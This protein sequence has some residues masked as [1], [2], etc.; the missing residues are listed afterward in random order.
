[1]ELIVAK[2][3]VEPSPTAADVSE[4]EESSST[5]C[6]HKSKKSL[7]KLTDI[8]KKIKANVKKGYLS[9][10]CDECLHNDPNSQ[11]IA[12]WLCVTCGFIGCE[13]E[14]HTQKHFQAARS[15]TDH[16]LYFS[17]NTRKFKC[18][19]CN[20]IMDGGEEANGPM[21][22]FV[23]DY[24]AFKK[25]AAPRSSLSEQN[26][27]SK[28]LLS[29]KSDVSS[30]S[31]T[32]SKK[33][34]YAE[35]T[36]RLKTVMQGKGKKVVDCFDESDR[37]DEQRQ[38][39]GLAVKVT[40][41]IISL[42]LIN[43][44]NTCFFNSTMQ[45]LMHT[46]TLRCYVKNVGI[47][48]EVE[49]GGCKVNVGEKQIEVS[50]TKLHLEGFSG[51]LNECLAYFLGEFY[52]GRNL[53]PSPLFSE[54]AIKAPRFRGW[55]QQDAHELLRCLMDGLRSEELQ[56][57]KNAIALNLK[58]PKS[59]VTKSINSEV[60]YMAKAMLQ[61]CGRPLLD[62]IFGGTLLQAIKCSKCGHLSCIYEEFLDLSIPIPSATSSKFLNETLK[63]HKPPSVI[64]KYQKKKE[65]VAARK[66]LSQPSCSLNE[67]LF[68]LPFSSDLFFYYLKRLRRK[69]RH[70]S[71]SSNR[72]DASDGEFA[73]AAQNE[74]DLEEDDD[75]AD[76]DLEFEK[77]CLDDVEDC[78]QTLGEEKDLQDNRSLDACLSAFT[79][80]EILSF[81]NAYECEKCC[82]SQNKNLRNGM[83][84]KTVDAEKRYFIYEPPTVLTLHLKR[85]EQHHSSS[86]RVS[87]SKVRGHVAFPLVLD[88]ASFC[89]KIVK[90][91]EKGR[92]KVLYALYGIVSHSGDLSGGHYVAY[93]RSRPAS[94]TANKFFCEAAKNLLPQN[95]NIDIFSEDTKESDKESLNG[96]WFYVSDSRVSAVDE[97][98][99]LDA[100]AYILFYERIA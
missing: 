28:N 17:L 55:A 62:A 65:K 37:K 19:C 73:S 35:S 5:M 13:K 87:T 6:K 16:P 89:T 83:K 50:R 22:T 63:I 95:P 74:S 23:N 57:Y 51:P 46:Y 18:F 92:R 2:P 54:I 59:A 86:G 30:K 3:V 8:R 10:V 80:K 68:F 24:F 7:F 34:K 82:L 45:C 12:Q 97:S 29:L 100:E 66:V 33:D 32:L 52:A 25:S 64:S 39:H 40:V 88:I 77:L 78:L 4:L 21:K 71:A 26:A 60:S 38:R 14:G 70:E 42:G 9:D 15:G 27:D 48:D 90:R 31:E 94:S 1:M 44:G 47:L 67:F 72:D 36:G 43:L 61:A 91:V 76:T 75:T 49:I 93:V 84:K 81:P 99:V 11:N 58:L 53:K 98:K 56:R 79:A 96:N 69:A 85:F 20:I 41:V